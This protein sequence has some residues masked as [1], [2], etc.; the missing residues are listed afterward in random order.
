[1]QNVNDRGHFCVNPLRVKE[2]K[3]QGKLNC[4]MYKNYSIFAVI[5]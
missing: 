2:K 5:W 3:N 1:M 4:G